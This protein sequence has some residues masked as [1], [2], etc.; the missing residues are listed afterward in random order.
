MSQAGTLVSFPIRD[1]ESV[2]YE[3][4]LGTKLDTEYSSRFGL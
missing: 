1:L 3:G 2:H 4:G